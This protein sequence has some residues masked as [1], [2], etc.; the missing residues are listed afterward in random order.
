MHKTPTLGR[1]L[2]HYPSND[3][4]I[5]CAYRSNVLGI[6][7]ARFILLLG[8]STAWALIRTEPYLLTVS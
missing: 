7:C 8:N 6:S 2:Y 3:V 5:E 4:E 1:V